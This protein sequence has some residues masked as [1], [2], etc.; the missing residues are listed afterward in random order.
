[1]DTIQTNKALCFIVR[2]WLHSTRNKDFFKIYLELYFTFFFSLYHSMKMASGTKKVSRSTYHSLP[3]KVQRKQ[4]YRRRLMT[5]WGRW[6]L[7]P[8]L[9]I[10]RMFRIMLILLQR[11]MFTST[12]YLT[13][14][15]TIIRMT[16]FGTCAALHLWRPLIDLLCS[17]LITIGWQGR[18]C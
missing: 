18:H 15:I 14:S 12:F 16:S 10:L 4:R 11:F 7:L 13:T 9:P 3:R 8:W 5:K 17:Q 2:F 1:M 6:S